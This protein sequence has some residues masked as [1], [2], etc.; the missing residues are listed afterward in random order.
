MILF[1]RQPWFICQYLPHSGVSP[2]LAR[3]Q[4]APLPLRKNLRRVPLLR[5]FL[6]GVG[7]VHRLVESPPISNDMDL[8]TLN[9]PPQQNF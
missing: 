8:N 7:S 3:V 6:R 2:V 1:L 5:L 9:T 4:T